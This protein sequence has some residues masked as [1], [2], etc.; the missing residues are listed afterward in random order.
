MSFTFIL[1]WVDNFVGIINYLY[2]CEKFLKPTYLYLDD[3]SY[4]KMYIQPNTTLFQCCVVLRIFQN[5]RT[6]CSSS[7]KSFQNQRT[8][9]SSYFRNLKEPALI[10][11]EL[12]KNEWFFDIFVFLK[13]KIICQS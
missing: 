5:Q 2:L 10:M 1:L 4:T 6:T 9:S 8:I 11:K 7:L 3:I 12:T 13:P